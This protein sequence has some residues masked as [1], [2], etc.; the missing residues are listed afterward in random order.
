MSP[1]PNT[2]KSNRL[3][4]ALSEASY[5]ALLPSLESIDLPLGKV[6]YESGGVQGYVY[7][8]TS[9]IVSLL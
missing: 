4:A 6:L 3:L 7:F 2:A 9:S 5:Q 1:Q 8:P